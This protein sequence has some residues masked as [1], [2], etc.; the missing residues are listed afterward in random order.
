MNEKPEI[1]IEIDED[2]NITFEVNN[3]KG[4]GCK[5]LTKALEDALGEV[6]DRNYK[7]EFEQIVT[8]KNINL[9]KGF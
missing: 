2:G 5:E 6:T 4:Q 9:N 8:H 7:E 3:V 1:I